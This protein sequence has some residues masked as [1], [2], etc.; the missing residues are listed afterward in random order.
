MLHKDKKIRLISCRLL[1]Y[2]DLWLWC[3]ANLGPH[4]RDQEGVQVYA[5]FLAW[6]GN[7][8]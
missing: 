6:Y 7:P 2:P 4:V 5:N 1:P 8:L 3:A